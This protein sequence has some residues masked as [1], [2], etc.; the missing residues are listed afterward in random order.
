MRAL[1]DALSPRYDLFNRLAS[2]GLDQRWRRR[3]I[4][5]AGLKPGARVLD[6]GAGTGD[7]ALMA[8]AAV[9]PTGVVEA[10]DLSAPMLQRARAKAARVPAG[11]HV[12]AVQAQAER[13][14]A[15]D[16]TYEAVVSGFVMRNVSDLGRTL[17]ESH[18]VLRPGGRLAILE[19]GRP[20]AALLRWGH[21][22]WLGVGTLAIGWLVTGLRGPFTY[23]R[24]SIAGF[25]PPE[26]FL[27]R[28][29]EHGFAEVAAVPL[30]GGAV[31]L[32]Q[33][34]KR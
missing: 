23:L 19:F 22:L 33:G 28:L 18:R 34:V 8:A 9:A 16:R 24:R 13:L 21:L 26:Q 10:L 7:L 5:A 4:A 11:W 2:L 30:L 31:I 27:A 3:A 20:R 1:F 12:R 6:L 15:A 14:P 32:Y 25:L 29:R 17:S